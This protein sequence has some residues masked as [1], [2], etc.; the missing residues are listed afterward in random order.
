MTENTGAN[1]NEKVTIGITLQNFLALL[2]EEENSFRIEDKDGFV[3]YDDEKDSVI[4]YEN[5]ITNYGNEYVNFFS[6]GVDSIII[7][8]KCTMKIN[9]AVGEHYYVILPP[10]IGDELGGYRKCEVIS[11]HPTAELVQIAPYYLDNRCDDY[12]MTVSFE[13]LKEKI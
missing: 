5:L 7:T 9:P 8:L 12:I 3:V 2:D 10:A 11:I 6:M 1:N 13:R 4:A